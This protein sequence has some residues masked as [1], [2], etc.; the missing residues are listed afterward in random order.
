MGTSANQPDTS[1]VQ[2]LR[3]PAEPIGSPALPAASQSVRP[4]AAS[5]SKVGFVAAITA[6]VTELMVPV[7]WF[8]VFDSPLWM[9][10]F[11]ALMIVGPF[12]M[13]GSSVTAIWRGR[14]RQPGRSQIAFWI[15]VGTLI[16]A[17]A[18]TT[19]VVVTL[20]SGNFNP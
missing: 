17:L 10:I 12:V 3:T 5:D 1:Q 6:L 4:S 9:V 18:W 8:G 20:T 14:H 2:P 7:I 13:I 16:P 11:L 15:G 19:F